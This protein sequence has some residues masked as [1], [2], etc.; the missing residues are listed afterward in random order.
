MGRTEFSLPPPR[1]GAEFWIT[2]INVTHDSFAVFEIY[3]F[4]LIRLPQLPGYCGKT[5]EFIHG[6][7][8]VER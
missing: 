3:F 5:I 6:R 2:P 1:C 8:T 4:G 7:T